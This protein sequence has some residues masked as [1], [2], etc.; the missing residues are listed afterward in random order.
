MKAIVLWQQ[1]YIYIYVLGC[2]LKVYGVH[3]WFICCFG[4]WQYVRHPRLLKVVTMATETHLCKI[5]D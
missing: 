4:L 3:I 5:A 2:H 1:I